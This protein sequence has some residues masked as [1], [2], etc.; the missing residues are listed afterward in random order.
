MATE[1]SHSTER[2]VST[3]WSCGCAMRRD[4]RICGRCGATRVPTVRRPYLEYEN[5][6][7]P[8]AAPRTRS[9]ADE[10]APFVY[11][12]H[13]C[14]AP[15]AWNTAAPEWNIYRS[16]HALSPDAVGTTG[17]PGA[18]DTPASRNVSPSPALSPGEHQPVWRRETLGWQRGQ[19]APRSSYA[20][21]SP[22]HRLADMLFMMAFGLAGGVIGGG[23]WYAVVSAAHIQF[24]PC[25]VL[26]GYL[27]GKG[28]AL[29][30]ANR[31]LVST[32]L[33]IILTFGGWVILTAILLAQGVLF[34]PLDIA[35]LIA[36]C[37]FATAPTR[38]LPHGKS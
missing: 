13:P 21:V 7:P 37:A 33:A 34:T 20:T 30:S 31:N 5:P 28:V 16:P 38:L 36:S 25:G 27:I 1:S 18:P 4:Q 32:L 24:G 8:Q 9:F 26:M 23:I 19:A 10:P 3:C 15:S 17:T 6:A 35:F 11:P 12:A 2:G 22:W 29:G 14:E